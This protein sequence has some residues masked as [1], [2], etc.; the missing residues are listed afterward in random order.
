MPEDIADVV[1]GN[2]MGPGGNVARVA[3]LAA[4]LGMGVTGVTVDRQCA[5]GLEAVNLAATL[6]RAGC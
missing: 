4:G 3:A 5:S 2:V 6:V 1:L